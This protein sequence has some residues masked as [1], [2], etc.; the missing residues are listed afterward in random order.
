[1]YLDDPN[2]WL[3][4]HPLRWS[5]IGITSLACFDC[6]HR[7]LAT[8]STIA[9]I[10]VVA[11]TWWIARELFGSQSAF[12][13]AALAATSPLQL[14]LGRRALADEFVCALVLASIASLLL[15]LRDQRLAWLVVWIAATTLA[16]A[17]KELF[18]FTYP[19]VLGFWWLRD[20]KLRWVWL[21]PPL[22]FFAVFSILARDVGSFFEI[23][24]LTASTAGA[25]Y[26]MQYQSGPPHRLL[27]DL[28][29]VAPIVT[30]VAIAALIALR[31][32]PLAML[33]FA[34]FAVHALL[35][36]QNL[37]Y[38]AA[39]DPLLRIVAAAFLVEQPRR[40]LPAG[41]VINAAVEL[42][43]FH[44]IFIRAQVY[45]PVTAALLRALKMLPR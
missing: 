22:L 2:L 10:C 35:P 20:R 23:A 5:W 7:T 43:L 9:G 42:L 21:L 24:R 28:M 6:T 8:I 1:M 45:D 3:F 27:I 38:I 11:L 34:M 31:R 36:S 17:A 41:L 16:I 29:A 12:V 15:Y 25:A 26:P 39:V 40:W 33:A 44:A 30:S 32:H 13:A 19:F 37:R 14:A 4:P 18:L